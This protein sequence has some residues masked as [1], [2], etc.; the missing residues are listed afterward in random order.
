MKLYFFRLKNKNLK[1]RLDSLVKMSAKWVYVWSL[2]Q[3]HESNDT[4]NCLCFLIYLKQCAKLSFKEAMGKKKTFT[5][6]IC[7]ELDNVR[8]FISFE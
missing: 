2:Q 5:C 1:R 6:L 7:V 3:V 8:T 4:I